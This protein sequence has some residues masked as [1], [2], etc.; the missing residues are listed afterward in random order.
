VAAS[1]PQKIDRFKIHQV[2]GQG[3]QGVVYLAEDPQLKRKV[4]IKSVNLKTTLP[5]D[6]NIEQLLTEARTV[7]KLQHANIVSIFD[8]GMQDNNPYLVLEFI[9]GESLQSKIRHGASQQQKIRI[10]R[11]ILSGAA[12]AHGQD[13]VH[14][15]IKPANIMLSEQGQA[16]IADFGL[17]YL[18]GA[19][20]EADGA[21]YGTPQYMAPEYIETRKHQ[22]VSDVFSIGLVCYELLTG[23]PA[24]SGEDVYQVLNA[25]ANSE[26][27][28][29]SKV[30][31]EIDEG[32][33]A[34]IL[35]SLEKDPSR[36][37]SDAGSMLQALNDYLALDNVAQ[38]RDNSDATVRFLLRRMRHKK[39]FPAFSH[40]ISVLNQ[41]SSSDTESLTTVSN[42]ILKDYSLTNKVLRLV[43]SAYY[44]RGGGKISTISRAVVM[45]GINPVRSIATGLMLFEHMQDKMQ[46]SQ[47][48]ENAVQALFSGLLANS[49]ARTL[50]VPNHE[51]A[52]L[53]ALL[54]Q[55]GKMLVA[56]YLHDEA[57]AIDKLMLQ[58]DCSE[59]AA[60][61]QV[62]G[63]SYPSLG[64]SVAREWGFPRLI[65]DSMIPLDFD[66]LAK[67]VNPEEKLQQISQFSDALGACLTLPLQQQAP[68]IQLLTQQFS[69]VLAIDG[70][71]VSMLL[72]NCHKELTQFSRL[73]QFD[74]TKS[75]YYQQISSSGDE[76]PESPLDSTQRLEFGN[77]DSAQILV[78]QTDPL[79]QT[80]DKVLTD[81]I[82]DITNTLTGEYSINQVM[83]MILETIYRALGGARVV[84]C[85]KDRQGSCIRA[86]YGYGEDIEGVIDKFSIPLKPQTDV[87]HVAF[88]NNVD[89]RIDDTRD[90]KIRS[91]IPDW[92]HRDIAA[93]SFTIFPIMIKSAPIALIYIDS[94]GS[95]PINITDNQLSLLKTLRNQAILAIRNLS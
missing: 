33:D 63:I 11:D 59:A 45:L 66:D 67:A 84:L 31:A 19:A 53:C 61:Q 47:L 43:N 72:E 58:Q 50:A 5:I 41:A 74:L 94:A 86:R 78:E 46:A 68:A 92:Y 21:L 65:T 91:R 30:N 44:N 55:L 56:F 3:S 95:E 32:L 48:K 82:Q 39:D 16:K 70:D 17:A 64:M 49:L 9:D 76:E 83:Q 40:T 60:V 23:E 62:L 69:S 1:F 87:F 42:T 81:G 80:A 18:T 89:I 77:S 26:V 7:S 93:R 15:D 37:F 20:G 14:C 22:K 38:A 35:K 75:L 90:E 85:L 73:I 6:G 71:K 24:F 12:A 79:S 28:P 8:I 57:R 4:A 88:K 36:R 25:I 10:M 29:P 2:L 52:F 54:Q 13:I 27:K 51:E 34:L